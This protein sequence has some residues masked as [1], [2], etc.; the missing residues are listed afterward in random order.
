MQLKIIK[1]S[2]LIALT[3]LI[4]TNHYR[5][6]QAQ[7]EIPQPALEVDHIARGIEKI[8]EKFTLIFKFSKQNK[9]DYHQYLAEKRFAEFKYAVDNDKYDLIEE[10]SSRY[11]SYL[12]RLSEYVLEK[13]I[14]SKKD[15]LLSMYDTHIKIITELQK[16][17]EYDSAWWL[18][19][20]HG[21][22]VAREFSS[23]VGSL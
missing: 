10:T 18:L 22:N 21:I 12:G 1:L 17:Y 7:E 6:S 8:Q 2:L 4:F 15:S 14:I 13:N 5:L 11:T 16:Q 3:S 20:Q 19:S 23:K 9:A